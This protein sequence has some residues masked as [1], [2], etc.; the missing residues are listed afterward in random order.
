MGLGLLQRFPPLELSRQFSFHRRTRLPGIPSQTKALA[1]QHA[2]SFYRPLLFSVHWKQSQ[3]CFAIFECS[4]TVVIAHRFQ[5]LCQLWH[6]NVNRSRLRRKRVRFGTPAVLRTHNLCLRLPREILQIR[7]GLGHQ[8]SLGMPVRFI[9]ALEPLHDA[10]KL[11][12]T[13]RVRHVQSYC[14]V[15]P[16]SAVLGAPIHNCHGILS[17]MWR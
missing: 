9:S 5:H 15:N 2:I 3:R 8:G 12:S 6:R 17:S 16:Y 14:A 4:G 10:L 11:R 13:G 7:D 1:S